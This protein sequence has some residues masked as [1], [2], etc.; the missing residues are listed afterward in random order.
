MIMEA[1]QPAE[2]SPISILLVEDDEEDHFLIG[3]FLS[4][5]KN[6]TYSLF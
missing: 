1:L 2:R 3:E 5:I 4:A 6:N